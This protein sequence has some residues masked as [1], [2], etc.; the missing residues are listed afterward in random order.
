[1]HRNINLI[2]VITANGSKR[3]QSGTAGKGEQTLLFHGDFCI[4][5]K[6]VNMKKSLIGLIVLSALIGYGFSSCA[7][8]Q[9]IADSHNAR[10][11][12]DWQ[13]VY[14]GTIPSGSGPGIKVRLKLNLNETYELSYEYLDKSSSPFTWTGLFKWD[15][16]GNIIT[17][18]IKDAPPYYMAAEGKLIQLDMKGKKISGKLAENYVLKKER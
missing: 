10:N 17:L 11:S 7:S 12:L 8:S 14:T 15:E 4:F 6:E 13:G 18:N 9:G 1:M 2:D 16:K 3:L 5:I